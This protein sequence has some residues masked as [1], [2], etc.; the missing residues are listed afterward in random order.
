MPPPR[1]RPQPIC[2]VFHLGMFDIGRPLGKGKFGRV[3]LVRERY[4]GYICA[5]KT[6]YKSEFQQYQMERQ[7]CREI[8]IQTN[9][10]HPNILKLYGHFHDEKRIFLIL[11]FAAQGELYKQL[12][13]ERRFS[14]GKAAQYTAQMTSALQH[15][16]RKHV[17]HRDIKPENI[18]I[19][20]H[21]E[22]KL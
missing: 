11:D 6:L 18:L 20:I 3:Y 19:G 13:K 1:L 8:E 10:C 22:L 2:K 15:L 12:R 4:S 5:L 17:I 21:G 9:L 7:V 16:H 14:E